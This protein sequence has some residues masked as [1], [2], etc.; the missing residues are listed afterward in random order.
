MLKQLKKFEK[1]IEDNEVLASFSGIENK[2]KRQARDLTKQVMQIFNITI[3]DHPRDIHKIFMKGKK[4][5]EKNNKI[6]N[7]Y[8]TF[9]RIFYLGNGLVRDMIDE[10]FGED[11]VFRFGNT[12]CFGD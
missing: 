1:L 8:Y 4:Y 7:A 10:K 11:G 12:S 5:F 3:E 2:T 9:N 6:N